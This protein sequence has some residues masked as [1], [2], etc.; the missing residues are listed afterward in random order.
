MT[1]YDFNGPLRLLIDRK[2]VE[3]FT[4]D[5]RD[6]ATDEEALGIMVSVFLQWD[7]VAIMRTLA[8]ALEDANFHSECA[9]VLRMADKAAGVAS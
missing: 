5:Y 9:L 7:G 2:K 8:A 3:A 1:G 4:P 6:K